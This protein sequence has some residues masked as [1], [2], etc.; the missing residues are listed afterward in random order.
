MHSFYNC[1]IVSYLMWK[2]LDQF[3]QKKTGY[4]TGLF[5]RMNLLYTVLHVLCIS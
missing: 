3:H 2:W 1:G 4:C 5:A